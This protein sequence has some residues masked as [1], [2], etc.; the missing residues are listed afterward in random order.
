MARID[1][2]DLKSTGIR[3]LTQETLHTDDSDDT[4][5]LLSQPRYGRPN[6]IKLSSY[7]FE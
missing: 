4:D 6:F 3:R 7:Q 2:E 1:K 5:S